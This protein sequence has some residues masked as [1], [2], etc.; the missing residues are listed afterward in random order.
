VDRDFWNGDHDDPG[1]FCTGGEEALDITEGKL[2][3]A[4]N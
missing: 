4:E 1:T 2:F 3:S